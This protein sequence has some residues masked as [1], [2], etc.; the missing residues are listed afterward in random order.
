MVDLDE[1]TIQTI[2]ALSKALEQTKFKINHFEVG[3]TGAGGIMISLDIRR[4]ET[5]RS[6]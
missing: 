3:E 2:H 5:L 4:K 6:E 1:D